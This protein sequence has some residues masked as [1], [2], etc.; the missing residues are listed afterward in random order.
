MV[1]E[2]GAAGDGR[3]KSVSQNPAPTLDIN[4][5]NNVKYRLMCIKTREV[6]EWKKIPQ[7]RLL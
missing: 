1:G 4:L 5:C 2:G 3:G 7:V 6:I